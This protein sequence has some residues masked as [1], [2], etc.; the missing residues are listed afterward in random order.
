MNEKAYAV[1]LSLAL[2]AGARCGEI[3]SAF[4]CIRDIYES[5][6]QTL[7]MSGVFTPR[8]LE[9]TEKTPLSDAVVQLETCE[10][11]GWHCVTYEENEYPELLRRTADPPVVLYV[12]GSFDYVNSSLCFGI[13]GTRN[14][15]NDSVNTAVSISAQLA[16]AGA[17]IVSGGALGIDS[18]AHR[19]ALKAGGK[20][21]AVLGCGLGTRYLMQGA[22]LREEI[23]K[24]GAVISEF[25]P[26]APASKTTFPIRN[27][28]ISGISRGVLVVEAGERSGSIIT[29]NCAMLQGRD[30]F[31][32]PGSVVSSAY[33]GANRLIRDGASAVTCAQDIIDEYEA[34]YPGQLKRRDYAAAETARGDSKPAKVIKKSTALMSEKEKT[35]YARFNSEPLYPG[36]IAAATGLSLGEVNEILTA[37]EINDY[38]I[39]VSGGR[40]TLI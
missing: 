40:F 3:L 12:N 2:G 13:V 4:D 32:V 22:F 29:A 37:L 1:W 17:V 15:S 5:D 25:S 14:P 26:F 20:T 24:N 9:K 38:V 28:I 19:G 35:V 34:L 11:N 30:V 23:S 27:R 18:A 7:R 36:D 39:S 21:I 8:Q 16:D 33:I 10:K 31:A 6:M